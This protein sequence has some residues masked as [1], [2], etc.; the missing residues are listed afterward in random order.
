M[1]FRS[2]P[3]ISLSPPAQEGGLIR[4]RVTGTPGVPVVI[5]A[6]TDLLQWIPVVTNTPAGADG[7]F[8]FLTPLDVAPGLHGYRGTSLPPP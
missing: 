7:G 1:L 4:F 3:P 8:D 6:S 2:R 5:H